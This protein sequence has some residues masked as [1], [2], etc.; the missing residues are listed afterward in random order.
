MQ[1]MRVLRRPL[2]SP[3]SK[4]TK[5]AWRWRSVKRRRFPR[6]WRST[7]CCCGPGHSTVMPS[8]A[9]VSTR[10][11]RTIRLNLPIAL[12][13]DGHRDRGAPRHRHGAGRRHRRRPP[14]PRRPPSRPRRC[15]RSSASRAAWW[16]I[17][18]P[19]PRTRRSPTR[20]ALMKR[21]RI[22]GIPVVEGG[23]QAGQAGRHP[24]QSRR[25]L[26]RGSARSR[27]PN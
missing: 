18:S 11:T 5:D 21:A 8:D 12:G 3:H 10:L 14:Q 15:A 1:R 26:R 23:R 9:D 20:C 16:S 25:A 24:H 17:R 22:S 27:S 13:G 2:P 4:S 6:D 7:T 19:S